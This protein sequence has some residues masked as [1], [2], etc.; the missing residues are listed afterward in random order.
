MDLLTLD[1][2]DTWRDRADMPG[3]KSTF[4]DHLPS[5]MPR[6]PLE[7][8][9]LDLFREDRLRLLVMLVDLLRQPR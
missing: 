2:L 6:G 8:R 3:W 1:L 5:L 9:F 4:R 7:L